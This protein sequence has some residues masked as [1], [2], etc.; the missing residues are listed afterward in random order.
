MG[1]IDIEDGHRALTRRE[2][3]TEFAFNGLLNILDVVCEMPKKIGEARISVNDDRS[4][5]A[6]LPRGIFGEGNI[7]VI[8]EEEMVPQT[9]EQVDVK[10][11]ETTLG[12]KEL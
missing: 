8:L 7:I 9:T 1:S 12:E 10:K 3:L 4:S 5:L 6:Y 2:R 11:P